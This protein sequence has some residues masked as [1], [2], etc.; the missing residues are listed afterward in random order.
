MAN[1]AWDN[2]STVGCGLWILCI[3]PS[4]ISVTQCMVECQ[5]RDMM[6]MM[7][8]FINCTGEHKNDYKQMMKKDDVDVER[9][10]CIMYIG[11]FDLKFRHF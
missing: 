2:L 3:L 11:E 4:A 8:K 7:E 9:V 5:E 6:N 10:T 1:P